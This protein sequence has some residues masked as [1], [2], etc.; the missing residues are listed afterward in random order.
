MSGLAN[1]TKS[2]EVIVMKDKKYGVIYSVCCVISCLI[3]AAIL[4]VLTI[5]LINYPYLGSSTLAWSIP[6][7]IFLFICGALGSMFAFRSLFGYLSIPLDLVIKEGDDLVINER[8]KTQ[9]RILASQVI[10]AKLTKEKFSRCSRVI[11]IVTN[12]KIYVL[13]D[14]LDENKAIER[15]NELFSKK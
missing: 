4:T 8:K 7:F 6:V 13:K 2:M 14:V 12:G 5:Y 15:L 3:W 9:H 10:E 1:S 11:H